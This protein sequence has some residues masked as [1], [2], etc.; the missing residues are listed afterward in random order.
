MSF[1]E[2]SNLTIFS[3]KSLR[4]T[5]EDLPYFRK[6]GKVESNKLASTLLVT[7]SEYRL[8]CLADL[9][10]RLDLFFGQRVDR[11]RFPIKVELALR[12]L[13]QMLTTSMPKQLMKRNKN[14]E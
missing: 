9:V 5:L 3:V 6:E 1:Q 2:L 12:Q 7:P 11:W 14:S 10:P 4:H 8:E 13:R